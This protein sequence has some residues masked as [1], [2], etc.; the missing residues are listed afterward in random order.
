MKKW[1]L[2]LVFGLAGLLA[3]GITYYQNTRQNDQRSKTT[4]VALRNDAADPSLLSVKVGQFV[5]FD[6]KDG[7]SHNLIQGTPDSSHE[8]SAGD[9]TSGVFK[10][11]EAWKVEFKKVGTYNFFDQLNPKIQVTVVS[12]QSKK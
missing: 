5:Q 9:L 11:N 10:G 12:Y 2:G 6:S 7:Q 1:Q 3:F 4:R 8:H